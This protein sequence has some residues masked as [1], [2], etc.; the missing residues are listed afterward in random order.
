MADAR[1]GTVTQERDLIAK[2]ATLT[3]LDEKFRWPGGERIAIFFNIA[4]E[5]WSDGKGPAIGPMGNPLPAGCFDTNA[6]GFGNYGAICGIWRLLDS[7]AHHDVKAGV[8][9]SGVL[10]ERHPDAVKAVAAG[11]HDVISHNYGQEIIPVMLSEEQEKKEIA[12]VTRLLTDCTGRAPTGWMSPRATPSLVSYR[13]LAE[14]GYLWHADAMDADLPYLQDFGGHNILAMPF[15]LEVNDMPLYMRYGDPPRQYVEMFERTLARLIER[16]S[17]AV[18]LDATAHAHVFGRPLGA[19]AFEEVLQ[20]A[21][22][23]RGVWIGT[24]AEACKHIR[25]YLANQA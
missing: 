11:G 21:K 23:T 19:W 20:I 25:E 7:L 2:G 10:A 5:A 9:V 15:T 14:A 16:E 3:R 6:L 4:F 8:M 12:R 24:R 17:G 22:R 1:R 18:Q 13:L